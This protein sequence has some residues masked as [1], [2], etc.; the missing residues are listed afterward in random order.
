[1]SGQIYE[2]RRDGNVLRVWLMNGKRGEALAREYAQTVLDEGDSLTL[3]KR[4][5]YTYYVFIVR[6]AVR[7]PYTLIL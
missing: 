3:R 1:M 7:D 6:P 5:G 2:V 4:G